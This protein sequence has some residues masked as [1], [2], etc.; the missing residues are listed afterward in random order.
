MVLEYPVI[1]MEEPL[2]HSGSRNNLLGPNPD[3]ALAHEYS[4]Q[5]AVNA[6]TP[7]AFIWA[8]EK[9]P[10]VPIENS[11]NFYQ[12]LVRAKVPAELHVYE[13]KDHGCGLCGS[14]V[15][16]STWPGLLRNWLIQHSYLPPNAPA[17]PPSEP[18]S[19]IW[20]PGFTGP[21]QPQQP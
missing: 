19:A 1:A 9:D 5:F 7:P 12:A 21:G 13:Y 10:A 6:Q 8:T 11:L 17:M 20:P 18:N 2:T 16:L 15:P 4:N 3:P 14:I